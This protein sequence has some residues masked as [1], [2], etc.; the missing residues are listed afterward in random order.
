MENFENENE[1]QLLCEYC[2]VY[3]LSTIKLSVPTRSVYLKCCY[4]VSTMLN[5]SIILVNLFLKRL[6]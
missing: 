5:C 6:L 2:G 3:N 4:C 1:C